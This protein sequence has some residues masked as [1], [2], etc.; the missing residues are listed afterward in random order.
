MRGFYEQCD[1]FTK[2]HNETS[3]LHSAVIDRQHNVS[4]AESGAI[5]EYICD[6]LQSPLLPS[7]NQD[8]KLHLQCKQWLY[9]QVSAQGP[10]MGQSMYF[11]RIAATQGKP[12]NFSVLR[13]GTEAK[14]CLQMM[15]DQLRDSGGPLW[16]MWHAFPMLPVPIGPV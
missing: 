10:M 3:Q 12:D 7:K 8:V 11:N 9:W 14:R 4:V 5:L 1:I 15:N 16:S 13:F 2:E 6:E